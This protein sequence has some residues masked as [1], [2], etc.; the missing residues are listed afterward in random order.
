V[1][2]EHS[3]D[4]RCE[5]RRD[6]KQH[7]Y[8]DHERPPDLCAAFMPEGGSVARAGQRGYC[9]MDTAE[10]PLRS[11]LMRSPTSTA[12]RV[13]ELREYAL[14][15]FM[16]ETKERS[17]SHRTII[18]FIKAR[19]NTSRTVNSQII[20]CFERYS[21]PWKRP[22]DIG[23]LRRRC[24]TAQS[25]AVNSTGVISGSCDTQ[26]QSAIINHPRAIPSK[27]VRSSP[28]GSALAKCRHCR[29]SSRK[30][31]AA[32]SSITPTIPLTFYLI[33]AGVVSIQ[34]KY[35]NKFIS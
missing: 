6:D 3:D 23:P 21:L 22:N 32:E 2:V 10:A 26:A 1:I 9:P 12:W 15:A 33:T 28:S 18:E 11:W 7:H 29:A 5:D 35:M 16:R 27:M 24:R 31:R 14:D 17:A 34:P 19:G 13:G 4:D 30:F 8:R 20:L 25:C